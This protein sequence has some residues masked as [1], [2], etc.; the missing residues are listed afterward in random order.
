MAP[1]FPGTN[2]EHSCESRSF[3]ARPGLEMAWLL[4][5]AK[6][7]KP[8]ALAC[9]ES[10]ARG[11]PKEPILGVQRAQPRRVDKGVDATNDDV[12]HRPAREEY[13]RVTQGKQRARSSSP[14]DRAALLVDFDC[15][16]DGELSRKGGANHVATSWNQL[17]QRQQ[18]RHGGR[19]KGGSFS[20]RAPAKPQH[21]LVRRGH[22]VRRECR[23]QGLQIVRVDKVHR[24]PANHLAHDGRFPCT[25]EPGSDRG[26]HRRCLE[27]ERSHESH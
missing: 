19:S 12:R 24:L 15:R 6:Q 26:A 21:S 11:G 13:E 16:L 1:L 23:V 7:Q 17:R 22:S 18:E 9:H 8:G 14:V 4:C 27:S 25:A 3:R 20:E 10:E 2:S 5:R